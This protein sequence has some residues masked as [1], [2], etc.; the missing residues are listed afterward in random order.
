M[1]DTMVLIRRA[2]LLL[3]QGRT[4]DAI[5]QLSEVLQSDPN[6]DHAL[7]LIARGRFDQR[8]F[9]EGMELVQRAIS[10]QPA[11]SY[12]YYLLAFGYFNVD[13]NAY[14]QLNIRKAIELHPY[15]PDYFGLWALLLLEKNQF[16]DALEK[17]NDGLSIDPENIAC[18]NTR[19]TALNKLN[20]T[21]ESIHTMRTVLDQDPEN[22]YTHTTVGWNLL[23]KGKQKEA[24]VHFR[25]ALR[26]N[27]NAEY[28]RAGLKQS[29]KANIPPYKWLLQYSFW[30]NNKSTKVRFIFP[31]AIYAGMNL[32]DYLTQYA[33]P[34]LALAGNILVG[35]FILVALASWFINPLANIFLF[36]HK[37]G[38]HA[39]TSSEKWSSVLST[40]ALVAAIGLFIYHLATQ[41]QKESIYLYA[42]LFT[43]TLA[44]PLGILE[45][46]I[47]LKNKAIAQYIAMGMLVMGL[48]WIAI[49]LA[50][51]LTPSMFYTYA[52]ALL[53]F[54]FVVPF[55]RKR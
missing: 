48:G 47:S 30:L 10:L 41:T 7:G 35:L 31:F 38:R 9:K 33:S 11:E 29:L 24:I 39:L 18:L 43:L 17:A 22:H 8:R 16:N 44:L 4:E 45:F 51:L 55:T 40:F 14:A 27:P 12:Y 13:N 15:Q 23:E 37:D 54:T 34:A 28:A 50:G 6:N 5:R 49:T 26:L 2:E 46:P 52:G 32:L 21:D 42:S 19:A 36:F 25:E 53:F 20:R 1:A 3:S